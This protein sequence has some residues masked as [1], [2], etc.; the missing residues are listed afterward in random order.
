MRRAVTAAALVALLTLG[1]CAALK[2]AARTVVDI[3]RDLCA[4]VTAERNGIT[5]EQAVRTFCATESQLEPWLDELLAAKQRAA[6][7]A[8]GAAR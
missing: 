5:T 8:D 1:A 4:M 6:A 3:A 2:P 7:R